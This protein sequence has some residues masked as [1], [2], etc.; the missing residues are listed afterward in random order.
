M[1]TTGASVHVPGD[2]VTANDDD[3]ETTSVRM[4]PAP[5]ARLIDS[6]SRTGS[7]L[8]AADSGEPWTVHSGAF[9]TAGGSAAATTADLSVAAVDPGWAYGTYELTVEEVGDGRFWAAFR[10]VDALNYFRVGPDPATGAYRLEKVVN[11]V[12]MPVAI[13]ITRHVVTAADGDRIRIAVRPD[14]GMF[15]SVNG[16]HVWDAGDTASIH[17]GRFGFATRSSSARFAHLEVAHVISSGVVSADAFERPDSASMGNMA[18]GTHYAWFAHPA[19][20]ITAGRAHV[21]S[22]TEYGTA[23]IDAASEAADVRVT[24]AE[25]GGGAFGIVF[26]YDE[27]HGTYFRFG[28]LQP[29]GAYDADFVSGASSSPPSSIER[30]ATVMPAAGDVLEVRQGLDGSVGCYVDGL[31]VLRFTDTVTNRRSTIY[32]LYAAG[33]AARFDDVTIVPE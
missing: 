15:V 32:G 4:P 8:G 17:V 31:L 21:L 24:M 1:L 16:V 19:W 10:I 6:F 9:A 27:L 2:P 23:R 22:S 18:L 30:L 11:G 33:S 26:R 20:G 13:A 7:G 28:P 25:V 29:G 5:D 3:S 12:A 14:D